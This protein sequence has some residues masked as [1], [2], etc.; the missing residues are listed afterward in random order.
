MGPEKM[1]PDTGQFRRAW[2]KCMTAAK[3][4]G[5]TIPE[6]HDRSIIQIYVSH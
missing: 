1:N 4:R 3:N 2:L 6:V 5:K